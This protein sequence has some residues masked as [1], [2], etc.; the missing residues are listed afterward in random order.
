MADHAERS[1]N[2]ARSFQAVYEDEGLF[3]KM[4]E[5]FPY[6]LQVFN[7]NGTCVMANRAALDMIGVKPELHIGKYNV[8]QDPFVLRNN[9]TA[10]LRRVLEGETVFLTGF[11]ASYQDMIKIYDAEERNI[12]TLLTDITYFPLMKPDNTVGCFVAFFFN[13][14]TYTGREDMQ[15][16][17]EYIEAHW[18]EKYSAAKAAKA[19]N[20]SGRH[21][22]R[23]FKEFAGIT[24]HNFYINIKVEKI[25]E[26]LKNTDLSISAAFAACGVDYHG[27]FA[28]VFKEKTGLTP[29]QYRAGIY[30]ITPDTGGNL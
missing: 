12:D 27:H 7:T 10:E 15:S 13:R 16:G 25:Q 26:Q 29:T 24:P 14:R 8:F 3:K 18:K 20:M 6:P 30:G 28:R 21:F 23:L 5:M 11:N 17:R 2:P 9:V 22:S 1:G 4:V 19:A